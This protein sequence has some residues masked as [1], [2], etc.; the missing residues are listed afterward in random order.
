MNKPVDLQLAHVVVDYLN[1]LLEHDRCAVAA[2][3]ANRVPC[4]KAMADHPTCQVAEQH[5]GFHVGMLGVL[6][7]MCGI[8]YSGQ[9]AIQA[10]FDDLDDKRGYADLLRF[11]V[12]RNDGTEDKV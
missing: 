12:C 2:L 5:G 7:G 6:N 1:D 8:H 9:G 10:C 4:N 11:R 3:I